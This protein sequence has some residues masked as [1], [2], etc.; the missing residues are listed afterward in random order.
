MH[1]FAKWQSMKVEM[2]VYDDDEQVLGAHIYL[3]VLIIL[4]QAV[5]ACHSTHRETFPSILV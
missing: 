2:P 1:V 3:L 5:M 4:T